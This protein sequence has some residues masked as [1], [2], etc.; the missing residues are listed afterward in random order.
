M[1]IRDRGKHVV[2][3]TGAGGSIGSE[4]V[5]QIVRFQP[6]LLVLYELSEFAMYQIEQECLTNFPAITIA[7]AVGDV[8]DV[9]LSL[10][11]ILGNGNDLSR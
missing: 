9:H 2:L 7:C 3:V 4:L 11:H 1:C 5:R 6:R 10:I 8:K